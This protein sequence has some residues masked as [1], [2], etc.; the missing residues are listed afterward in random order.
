MRSS[1]FR[2]FLVYCADYNCAHLAGISAGRLTIFGSWTWSLIS[3]V[4]RAVKGTPISGPTLIG[5]QMIK[6]NARRPWAPEDDKL[7][8]ELLDAAGASRMGRGKISVW[9]DTS[10]LLGSERGDS[11]QCRPPFFGAPT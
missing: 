1:G 2:G 7:L 11:R 6:T 5:R 3:F 4:R 9:H 10:Y 8:R